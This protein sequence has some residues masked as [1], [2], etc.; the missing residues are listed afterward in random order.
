VNVL[1]VLDRTLTKRSPPNKTEGPYDLT[2]A[3]WLRLS[4]REQDSLVERA[5][6][7][8]RRRGFPVY[9]LSTDEMLSQL[10]ALTRAA[11]WYTWNGT[12]VEGVGVPPHVEV[13]LSLV[14]LRAGRDT[15]LEVAAATV[16]GK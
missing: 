4:L 12:V 11:A 9:R 1:S 7:Y 6:R 14:D 10:Q 3:Q 13:P 15:Q 5:F 16:R 2:G 8:W